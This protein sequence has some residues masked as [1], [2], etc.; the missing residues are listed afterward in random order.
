[1]TI[2]CVCVIRRKPDRGGLGA[3]ADATPAVI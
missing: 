2:H 1:M 3:A